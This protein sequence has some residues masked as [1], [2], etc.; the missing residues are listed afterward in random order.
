M[1]GAKFAKK[2]EK[3]LSVKQR[4]KFLILKGEVLL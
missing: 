3:E 1:F 4:N 2:K